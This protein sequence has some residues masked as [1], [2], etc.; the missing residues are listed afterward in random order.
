MILGILLNLIQKLTFRLVDRHRLLYFIMILH[1][2]IFKIF[3]IILKYYLFLYSINYTTN[4]FNSFY[5]KL[6]LIYKLLVVNYIYN[7]NMY[8]NLNINVINST[9]SFI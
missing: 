4:L 6:M 7:E 5:C 2:D 9:F 3:K 8:S 1:N